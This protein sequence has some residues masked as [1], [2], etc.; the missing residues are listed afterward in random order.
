MDDIL[1][2]ILKVI[3]SRSKH[4]TMTDNPLITKHVNKVDKKIIFEITKSVLPPNLATETTKLIESTKSMIT[5]DKIGGKVP[6]LEVTE[7]V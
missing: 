5:K 3:F 7:V 2:Q 4:E 6:H 1:H